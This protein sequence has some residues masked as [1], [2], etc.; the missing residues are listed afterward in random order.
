MEG[1]CESRENDDTTASETTA[2]EGDGGRGGSGADDGD[3]G[4]GGSGAESGDGGEGRSKT[5][6]EGSE[7]KVRRDDEWSEIP[8][9]GG[10][11]GRGGSGAD[12]GDGGCEESGAAE[13]DDGTP[14]PTRNQLWHDWIMSDTGASTYLMGA[15]MFYDLAVTGHASKVPGSS[16]SIQDIEGIGGVVLVLFHATLTLDIGGHHVTLSDVPVI[17][18]HQGLLLGNDFHS[19]E[20]ANIDH[21]SGADASGGYSGTLSLRDKDGQVQ[22]S[23]RFDTQ[24]RSGERQKSLG[25]HVAEAA[26]TGG[27]PLAYV[28]KA[29][30][31]PMWSDNMIRARIPHCAQ[32]AKTIAIVPLADERANEL[33]IL[34]AP[35]LNVPDKDGYV[36]VRVINVTRAP[37]PLSQGTAIA[38]FIVDPA[39]EENDVEFTT[40][41]IMQKINIAAHATEEDLTYIRRMVEQRRRLFRSTIGWA[42]LFQAEIDTPSVDSGQVE[43]PSLRN[44]RYSPL[45][46]AALKKNVD[47]ML[48][49]HI[50]ER[51]RSPYNALPLLIKKP[52]GE[53]R[54]V[55]DF[56]RLNQVVIKNSYPLPSIEH[57]LASLGKSSLFTTADLLQGFFQ[58]ELSERARLKTAFGT[59]FGQFAFVRL[60][61][62]LTSAPGI[63]MQAVDSALRGL[64]PEMCLAFVDDIIIPSAGDMRSH[65]EDVSV[66]FGRLIEAGFTVRCDKVHIGKLEVPYLGFFVSKVGTRPMPERTAAIFAFCYDQMLKDSKAAGSFAGMIGFYSRFLPHLHITLAPFHELKRKIANDSQHR[67]DIIESLRFRAAFCSLQHAL[68]QCVALA[69]PDYQKP[70]HLILDAAASC[71]GGGAL[72]QC[73]VDADMSTLRPLAMLS[74]SFTDEQFRYDVRSQECYVIYKAYK[75]WRPFLWGA[76]SHVQTDHQSL[77]WLMTGTHRAGDTTLK[78]Q[79]F[80][81]QF[82]M[83]ISWIPGKTNLVGDFFSRI[84]PLSRLRPASGAQTR[85]EGEEKEG[86]RDCPLPHARLAIGDDADTTADSREQRVRRPCRSISV[87]TEPMQ[88]ATVTAAGPQRASKVWFVTND[89]SGELVLL[90]HVRADSTRDIQYDTYGGKMEACDLGSPARCALRECHEE[91]LLPP[92]WSSVMQAEIDAHPE[93]HA[94]I[95]TLGESKG[96]YYWLHTWIVRLP[97]GTT[98]VPA[99][100]EDGMGEAVPGSSAWRPLSVVISNIASR[101]PSYAKELQA[102]VARVCMPSVAAAR[103]C[104]VQS[105]QRPVRVSLMV[106]PDGHVAIGTFATSAARKTNL[107]SKNPRSVATAVFLVIRAGKPYILVETIDGEAQLPSV[108]CSERMPYR[109]ALAD[110]LQFQFRG[111]T[112]VRLT[113]SLLHH[114]DKYKPRTTPGVTYFVATLHEGAVIDLP[115]ESVTGNAGFVEF[116]T[117]VPYAFGGTDDFWF[118]RYLLDKLLGRVASP[119]S[120]WVKGKERNLKQLVAQCKS[121]SVQLTEYASLGFANAATTPRLPRFGVDVDAK[122]FWIDSIEEAHVVG[123]AMRAR[124]A[125]GGVVALDLEGFLGGPRRRNEQI[126]LLQLAAQAHVGEEPLVG[127]FDIFRCPAILREGSPIRE[128]LQ[129]DPVVKVYHSGRGDTLSLK[130]LFGIELSNGFDTAVADSILKA[131]DLH[132]RRQLAVTLYDA[133]GDVPL[134]VKGTLEFRHDYDIFQQRPLPYF[135]FQYAYEDVLYCC[136]LYYSLHSALRLEGYG[137]LITAACDAERPPFSDAVP[138]TVAVAVFDGTYVYALRSA[139]GAVS[140]P[141][142]PYDKAVDLRANVKRVWPRQ[143]GEPLPPLRLPLNR[144]GKA[145]RLGTAAMCVTRVESCKLFLEAVRDAAFVVGTQVVLVNVTQNSMERQQSA[146]LQ[147]LGLVASRSASV[148]IVVGPT[149]TGDRAAI[150][151]HDDSR[152]LLLQ[153]KK[154]PCEFPSTAVKSNATPKE[155]AILALDITMGAALHKGGSNSHVMPNTATVVS[156]ALEQ[157]ELLTKIG[158]SSYFECRLP[159]KFIDQYET[160]FYASRSRLAGH[161]PNSSEVDKHPFFLLPQ[162]TEAANVLNTYDAQAIGVLLRLREPA[163]P[164]Q[165]SEQDSKVTAQANSAQGVSYLGF[166]V[167]KAGTHPTPGAQVHPAQG[168]VDM[169]TPRPL[170]D[171]E[172]TA[173]VF[174]VFANLCDSRQDTAKVFSAF[175]RARA[176]TASELIKAQAEDPALSPLIAALSGDEAAAGDVESVHLSQHE[177]VAGV[178][179]YQHRVVTPYSL[180]NRAIAACHDA[181]GH[182]GT[183]RIFPLVARQYYWGTRDVMRASVSEFIGT[184]AVCANTK[185]PRHRAGE[186]H[187]MPTGDYCWDVVGVDKYHVGVRTPRGNSETVSYSDYHG[188][189]IICEPCEETLD[190]EEYAWITIRTLFRRKGVPRW[191]V[192]DRGSILIAEVVE[193]LFKILGCKINPSTAYHHRTAGLV[194]RWHS[195]LGAMIRAFRF[196][197]QSDD[198]DLFIPML[199]LAYNATEHATTG[200]SS[201]FVE[202]GREP[203]LPSSLFLDQPKSVGLKETVKH[204]LEQLNVTS[205]SL[206]RKLNTHAISAKARLDKKRD[207]KLEFEIGDKVLLTKGKY[208]DGV[209]PKAEFPQDG[210]FTITQVLEGGN[211]RIRNR[212]TLRIHDVVHVDRLVPLNERH[213]RKLD[214]EPHDARNGQWPVKAILNC[215][216]ITTE[217]KLLGYKE[218]EPRLQYNIWWLDWPKT[219]GT[220]RESEHLLNIAQLVIDYHARNGW[221][222]GFEP[223]PLRTVQVDEKTPSIPEA[224]KARPHFRYRS[225]SQRA[226]APP[227]A[228]PVQPEVIEPQEVL[229]PQP[230]DLTD[231]FPKGSR[232]ETRWGADPT[233][234]PGVVTH[235]RIF[236][237]RKIEQWHRRDRHIYVLYDNPE[238]W[239]KEPFEHALGEFEVRFQAGHEPPAAAQPIEPIEPSA[240]P[241]KSAPLLAP[242]PPKAPAR[243]AKGSRQSPRLQ[244]IAEQAMQ[245]NRE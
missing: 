170:A 9:S 230:R 164:S 165:H 229:P 233:W 204:V 76:V 130:S 195:V 173:A 181:V 32:F 100:T 158:N 120:T 102:V 18:G 26:T 212:N 209:L 117:D 108:R 143:M 2:Y 122:A 166:F 155:A 95:D 36:D 59:P 116:T 8:H 207:V 136:S 124:V 64:P 238:L 224:T 86:Q 34:V 23:V 119:R 198:W 150:L 199:E 129:T 12:D 79:S 67:R 174:I 104:T 152:V 105:S 73:E 225:H 217:N 106:K 206:K 232:V 146:Q 74:F 6:R 68:A 200:Y 185:V 48:K 27:S 13:R 51:T 107:A 126:S 77:K 231:R 50:I 11:G 147:Y 118:T 226:S 244:E 188:R 21:M 135:M 93:G 112:S 89:A 47:K 41:E 94:Q 149:V 44:M 88:V 145:V 101:F 241:G 189:G 31:I 235:T 114:A 202:S 157:M 113:A 40:D 236:S 140:L 128:L 85:G 25:V 214:A 193:C 187:I 38:R 96:N 52:D 80:L 78:W 163:G 215:R 84:W 216:V 186:A 242:Q 220:W 172:F 66:V 115:A 110:Y 29:T 61:M 205:D 19:L 160:S 222:P 90:S 54:T 98:L 24:P 56:R 141:Y 35:S 125:S 148:N 161:R 234:W 171:V 213:V 33:G 197:S 144:L 39:V 81:Q 151:L 221:P 37:V 156:A 218:G 17:A 139:Q 239:G 30:T 132:S 176:P 15:D 134:A 153:R 16:S 22:G 194:E 184:C 109:G 133:L 43:P 5:N 177:L 237:P 228:A 179:R 46:L 223:E 240:P 169:T 75:E 103:V 111:C 182:L 92:R 138:F 91:A 65:M 167:S 14:N 245:P 208:V 1:R 63:F 183:S 62:G 87:Q 97:E 201:F 210:P 190:A 168:L 211:Y 72:G 121:S 219:Y 178:L 70:F 71:G 10:D 175:S 180:R 20:R 203:R 45:E 131:R 55:L 28:S 243:P 7:S 127:A 69:R 3:G 58:I 123:N 49:E 196:S 83:D 42:H 82:D 191:L 142:L 159:A 53:F 154:G 99:F 57:N 192:S 4:R 162:L 227:A 137:A 60:P